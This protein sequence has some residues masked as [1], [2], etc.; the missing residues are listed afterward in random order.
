MNMVERSKLREVL[1]K[2]EGTHKEFFNSLALKHIAARIHFNKMYYNKPF[3]DWTQE[4]KENTLG[5]MLGYN[6]IAGY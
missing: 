3:E 4:D 5:W 2:Y 6:V 1:R